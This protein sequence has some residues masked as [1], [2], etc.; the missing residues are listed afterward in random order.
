MILD[1]NCLDIVGERNDGMLELIIVS[2]GAF[3]DSPEQ[4]TLLMD[5]IENYIGYAL[6]NEIKTDFPDYSQ[7]R[8]VIVLKLEQKPSSLLLALCEKITEWVESYE[9]KFE[10]KY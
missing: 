3:D 8:I 7:D 6:S 1:A 9:L 10:L 5:K 2:S 4:Q